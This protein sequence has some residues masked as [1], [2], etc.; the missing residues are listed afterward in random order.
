MIQSHGHT[1]FV[2]QDLTGKRTRIEPQSIVG[3]VRAAYYEA[4][5][6]LG[7]E[8]VEPDNTPTYSP[9]LTR[10]HFVSVM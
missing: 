8:V 4:M 6:Q 10:S 2:G 1:T 5:E 7:E 9:R 3:D